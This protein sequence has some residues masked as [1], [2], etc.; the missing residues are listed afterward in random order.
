VAAY[1]V[2]GL[3]YSAATAVAAVQAAR[4]MAS[5]NVGF[6]AQLEAYEVVGRSAPHASRRLASQRLFVAVGACEP[7]GQDRCVAAA[8]AALRKPQPNPPRAWVLVPR[9][10]SSTTAGCASAEGDASVVGSAVSDDDAMS[11]T[12]V[13]GTDWEGTEDTSAFGT[14]VPLPPSTAAVIAC[15]A[16]GAALA[17]TRQLVA[18]SDL[19]A[20]SAA[21]A[22][23]PGRAGDASGSSAPAAGTGLVAPP[24]MS[25]RTAPSHS[26]S[27]GGLSLARPTV[28]FGAA[29]GVPPTP[30]GDFAPGGFGPDT[31]QGRCPGPS[32]VRGG[33]H[34]GFFEEDEEDVGADDEDDESEDEGADDV[35]DLTNLRSPT[36]AGAGSTLGSA[37]A[38]A[39]GASSSSAVGAAGFGASSSSAVGAAGFGASKRK[40]TAPLPF[41]AG[42]DVFALDAAA[43]DAWGSRLAASWERLEA[44]ARSPSGL[45]RARGAASAPSSR[46]ASPRAAGALPGGAPAIESGTAIHTEAAGWR[47]TCAVAAS[48]GEGAVCVEAGPFL[49][50]GDADA[51][52]R[53][54]SCSAVVGSSA[55]PPA[56][57]AANPEA[58][59]A[60]AST[61][62]VVWLAGSAVRLWLPGMEAAAP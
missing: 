15:E 49:T 27:A 39:A 14:P 52:C 18:A 61:G 3:G 21:A 31:G 38:A 55:A 22:S 13:A 50:L 32:S 51:A 6:L 53:C 57:A 37:G 20:A 46:S 29:R 41:V 7:S 16:C 28:G 48:F 10:Q 35:G 12:D 9:S 36:H 60:A 4:H 23:R 42:S 47:A 26:L 17:S 5:P 19:V 45:P 34:A 56:W 33:A 54:F 8:V 58:A 44:V 25:W 2:A 1:L 40:R 30:S 43:G 11:V 59:G 24:L 62:A